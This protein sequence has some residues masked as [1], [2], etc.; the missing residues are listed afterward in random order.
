MA[1]AANAGALEQLIYDRQV[2]T[3]LK[4]GCGRP[5]AFMEVLFKSL[6]W[7]ESEVKG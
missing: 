1:I 2:P 5:G 4:C 3:Y 7:E 6:E